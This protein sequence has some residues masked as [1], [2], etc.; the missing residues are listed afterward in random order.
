MVESP[1]ELMPT[2]WLP[3][4]QFVR[5][6]GGADAWLNVFSK[7]VSHVLPRPFQVTEADERDASTE[8]SKLLPS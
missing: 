3:G 6:T 5:A 8:T 2:E 7:Q 4:F 1:G